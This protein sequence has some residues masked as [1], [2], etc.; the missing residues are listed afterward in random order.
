MLSYAALSGE[1]PSCPCTPAIL[2]LSR[3]WLKVCMV[4]PPPSTIL[5]YINL[6]LTLSH[7]LFLP[8][9]LIPSLPHS[10]PPSFPPSLPPS[11]PLSLPPSFP[12][13][14]PPPQAFHQQRLHWNSPT[15]PSSSSLLPTW[16]PTTRPSQTKSS[17]Q[18]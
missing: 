3:P 14:L 10:L 6:A 15:T 11:F 7:T 12:P 9:S 18:R 2:P 4:Y 16:R 1:E 17:S 13:S 5:S 8:P